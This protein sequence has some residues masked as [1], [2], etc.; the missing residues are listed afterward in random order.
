MFILETIFNDIHETHGNKIEMILENY[1]INEFESTNPILRESAC[2]LMGSLHEYEFKNIELIKQITLKLSSL[3]NDKA[4]PVKVMAAVIAPRL[5]CNKAAKELLTPYVSDLLSIYINLINDID[6]EE[7]VEGLES[8]I[9]NFNTHIKSNAVA[10]TQEL[11]RVYKRIMIDDDEDDEDKKDEKTLLA[12]SVT[13][14]LIKIIELF[15]GSEIFKDI[16]R[17]IDIVVSYQLDNEIFNSMSEVLDMIGAIVK[18]VV[19][20]VTW[21]YFLPLCETLLFTNENGIVEGVGFE[22]INDYIPV[23]SNY[24]NK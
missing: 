4:L 16:E 20:E 2:K 9:F 12:E 5:L 11:V 14:A 17:H 23:L 7:I 3:L 1:I 22:N 19:T 21:S 18:N 10:L 6:L 24:I 15:A 13:R 8:I